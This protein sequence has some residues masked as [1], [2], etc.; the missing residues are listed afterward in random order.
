MVKGT[1][2]FNALDSVEKAPICTKTIFSENMV[3]SVHNID[4]RRAFEGFI[5]TFASECSGAM[6]TAVVVIK[7]PLKLK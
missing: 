1:K 4:Q 6:N 3:N 5:A 7:D 2:Q